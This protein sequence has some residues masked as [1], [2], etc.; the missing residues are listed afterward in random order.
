[1]KSARLAS[2]GYT[3]TIA[4][5]LSARDASR[6]EGNPPD[7]PFHFDRLSSEVLSTGACPLGPLDRP[8]ERHPPQPSRARIVC[9]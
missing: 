7:S 1:M 8:G 2:R 3:R 5:D 6:R 9:G 4:N